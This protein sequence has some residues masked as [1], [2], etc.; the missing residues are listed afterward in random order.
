MWWNPYREC[1]WGPTA[2]L[3]QACAGQG[4]GPSTTACCH[5]RSPG[6]GA[7]LPARPASEQPVCARCGVRQ[8]GDSIS[9]HVDA[10][11]HARPPFNC[12]PASPGRAAQS[13]W[14]PPSRSMAHT[15]PDGG[16]A[17]GQPGAP[18]W[19]LMPSSAAPRGVSASAVLEQGRV[20]KRST[21]IGRTLSLRR[22]LPRLAG[23]HPWTGTADPRTLLRI[24]SAEIWGGRLQDEAPQKRGPSTRP[25]GN[26]RQF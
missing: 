18:W 2:A 25:R 8:A 16:G 11:G 20:Q 3:A 15:L 10:H 17:A 19:P 5:L 9:Q 22:A 26:W 1:S 6:A 13:M 14:W 4:V 21:G 23:C 24:P 12:I 7:V